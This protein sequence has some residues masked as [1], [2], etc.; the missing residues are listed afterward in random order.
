MTLGTQSGTTPLATMGTPMTGA[1]PATTDA[2]TTRR[3]REVGGVRETKPFYRTSEFIV[4]VA[5]A[6][7]VLVA[8][9]SDRDTLNLY[10]TW[11]LV[12]VLAAA[13][14]VSRGVAKAGGREGARESEYVDIR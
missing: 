13:Y 14:I 5:T 8:G 2:R 7:I 4:F 3:T 6:A 10:R 1:A 12:T 9:Y 11:Q